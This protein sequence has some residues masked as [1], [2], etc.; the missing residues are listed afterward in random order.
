ML[1]VASSAGISPD[2]YNKAF[3]RHLHASV[4]QNGRRVGLIDRGQTQVV[5]IFSLSVEDGNV[6]A[7]CSLP[8]IPDDPMVECD[9]TQLLALP[10]SDLGI[11]YQSVSSL[12]PLSDYFRHAYTVWCAQSIQAANSS[13]SSNM[14]SNVTAARPGFS[15]GRSTSAAGAGNPLGQFNSATSRQSLGYMPSYNNGR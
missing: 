2:A 6:H 14:V 10:V 4:R 1:E 13:P 9:V 11:P 7:L 5:T 12:Q 15:R 8:Q 3:V